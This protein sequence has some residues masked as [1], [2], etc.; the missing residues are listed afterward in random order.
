VLGVLV[1]FGF[2]LLFFETSTPLFSFSLVMP[3]TDARQRRQV[4]R[5]RVDGAAVLRARWSL[6]GGREHEEAEEELLSK[7]EQV[8]DIGRKLVSLSLLNYGLALLWWRIALMVMM[9]DERGFGAC[10]CKEERE[11]EGLFCLRHERHERHERQGGRRFVAR[12]REPRR[13]R[14]LFSLKQPPLSSLPKPNHTATKRHSFPQRER[15]T[16][17]DTHPHAAASFDTQRARAHRQKKPFRSLFPLL[18]PFPPFLL[19]LDPRPH[20]R[21][22]DPGTSGPRADG[23][24][25]SLDVGRR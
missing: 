12:G 7:L 8:I 3:A 14:R 24:G 25:R 5:Y 4:A 15:D 2:G 19:R 9:R 10:E 17:T 16:H 6:L 22:D 11:R 1:R 21:F 13:R 20:L 23:H 18:P